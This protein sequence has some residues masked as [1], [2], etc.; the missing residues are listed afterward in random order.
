MTLYALFTLLLYALYPI[1]YELFYEL[2]MLTRSAFSQ[3]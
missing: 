3:P 1:N 2:I